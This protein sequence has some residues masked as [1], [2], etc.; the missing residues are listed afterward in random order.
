MGD[1]Q[2]V[3]GWGFGLAQAVDEVIDAQF[4]VL[5]RLRQS[6]GE[7]I[8]LGAV[9]RLIGQRYQSDVVFFRQRRYNVFS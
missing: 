3:I 1:A 4:R 5:C 8:A 6:F 2:R 9:V 7:A